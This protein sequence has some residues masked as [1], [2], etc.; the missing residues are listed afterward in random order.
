MLFSKFLYRCIEF[1]HCLLYTCIWYKMQDSA[2]QIWTK[3]SA[4]YN[5]FCITTLYFTLYQP[6]I[7]P[8]LNTFSL[9]ILRSSDFFVLINLVYKKKRKLFQPILNCVKWVAIE[10]IS[11]NLL[12]CNFK[13]VKTNGCLTLKW[14]SIVQ[15]YNVMSDG[16]IPFFP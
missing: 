9:C 6:F 8:F 12:S 14:H 4:F 16:F 10:F 3:A 15:N 7:T 11:H 5:I 2:P 1:S 13:I